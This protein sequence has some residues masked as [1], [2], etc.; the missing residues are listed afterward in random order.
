M[1]TTHTQ[2]VGFRFRHQCRDYENLSNVM[3][4]RV[5]NTL[6]STRF[7]ADECKIEP[8]FVGKCA[9]T[10]RHDQYVKHANC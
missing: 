2:Y 10:F 1:V 4:Y 6:T 3:S 9:Q 8:K 5:R 7:C